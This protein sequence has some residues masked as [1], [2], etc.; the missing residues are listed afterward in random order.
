MSTIS[1]GA[2]QALGLGAALVLAGACGS[3]FAGVP[4][5]AGV[6][7]S[8]DDVV[9]AAAD[10]DAATVTD[11]GTADSAVPGVGALYST[12]VLS[13]LAF[14]DPTKAFKFYTNLSYDSS[15][16]VI[17]KIELTP[18]KATATTLSTS[19]KVGTMVSKTSIPVSASGRFE[20]ALGSITIPGEANPITGRDIVIDGATLTGGFS[21]PGSF[22]SQLSGTVVSPLTLV[23]EPQN[24]NALHAPAKDGDA[25]P[26]RTA[27]DFVCTVPSP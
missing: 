20:L 13:Q 1:F 27:A 19:E 22:C 25:F 8:V 21:A 17:K 11:T 14:G 26:T 6:D 18:I 3:G 10:Q 12:V 15:A 7:G 23:L 24:N 4:A 5:E 2:L 16:R 9:D